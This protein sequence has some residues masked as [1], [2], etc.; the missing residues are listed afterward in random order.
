MRLPYLKTGNICIIADREGQEKIKQNKP[1]ETHIITIKLLET[2]DKETND[3]ETKSLQWERI[4]N[5]LKGGKNSN[6]I[7][8]SVRNHEDQKEMTYFLRLKNNNNNT[9]CKSRILCLENISF[10]NEKE[11]KI[12]QIN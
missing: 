3:K 9:P 6:A 10:K 12:L 5:V 2:N 1:N 8:Y 4:S 11:T 7:K